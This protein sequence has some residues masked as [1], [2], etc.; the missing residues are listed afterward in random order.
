M[1]ITTLTETEKQL[2]SEGPGAGGVVDAHGDGGEITGVVFILDI[3]V[4]IVI[5]V[6]GCCYCQYRHCCDY[7][8]YC[9][10]GAHMCYCCYWW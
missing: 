7:W 1:T 2:E 9:R 4:I 8:N 3:V 10:C 5:V 6:D